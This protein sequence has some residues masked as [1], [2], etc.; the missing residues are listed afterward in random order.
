MLLSDLLHF[1]TTIRWKEKSKARKLE[2][3]DCALRATNT[4]QGHGKKIQMLPQTIPTCLA[5]GTLRQVSAAARSPLEFLTTPISP[6]S[7]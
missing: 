1:F 5:A 4:Q 7:S 6:Q 2:V 3:A